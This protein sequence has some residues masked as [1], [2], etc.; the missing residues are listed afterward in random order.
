MGSGSA[1][2]SIEA[3]SKA[4][5]QVGG[6]FLRVDATHWRKVSRCPYAVARERGGN[7]RA[8]V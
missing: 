8:M 3:L 4:E 6:E 2:G 5:R 1:V 7:F